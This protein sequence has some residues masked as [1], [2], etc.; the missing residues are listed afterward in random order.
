M[1]VL[2]VPD[3]FKGSL[4]AINVC[5]IIEKGICSIF[6]NAEVI[7]MPVADGGEGTVDAFGI[8]MDCK[9]LTQEVTGPLGKKVD[10][11]FAILPDKTAVIEMSAASGLTLINHE[12][13]NP[14]KTTTF[15]FG[16][17]IRAALDQG[18]RKMIL[19]L[20]GSATNDGGAGMAQALGF[21]FKDSGG[22]DLGFGGGELNKLSFIDQSGRD[23]RI[24]ACEFIAAC[25]VTNP[26]CGEFGASAVYGPQ[27]G[28]TP[29]IVRCLD[30]NLFHFAS[31]IKDQ[32][33]IDILDVPGAGAAGGLG[34]GVIAFLN[35]KIRKGVEV[36]LDAMG[37]D[38]SLEL[39]DL[40]ITGEGKMDFQSAFGK[41][42]Y[43]V[44]TR[45]KIRQKPV[46]A[47]VGDIGPGAEKLYEIGIDTIIST[48]NRA[49]SLEEAMRD[50]GDLLLD[51]VQRSM[52]LL[53]IGT[54]IH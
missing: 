54:K 49:M 15:G 5:K 6:K 8:A 32:M 43:G 19:G 9:M 41:V 50:S 18:C 13:R 24:D 25:D 36:I 11:V 35:A 16:E 46:I 44:A 12:E 7:K 21:K 4:T 29:G 47:F 39:A 51:A 20:G 2:V 23:P 48:V 3:S 33:K 42:P 27:K 52:R 34:G 10:A 53:K 17:L 1:K 30:N 22:N 31:L 26:L 14:L 38:E 37:F 28:A 40:V 45:A